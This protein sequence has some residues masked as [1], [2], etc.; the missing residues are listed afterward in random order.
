MSR[1]STRYVSSNAANAIISEVGPYRISTDAL[2]ALNQFL[3][4]ILGMLLSKAQSLDLSRI[5]AVALQILP[6][7]LGKN[8]IVEAELEVKTLTETEVI[9]YEAYERM[10]QLGSDGNFPLQSSIQQLR[11]R[12]LYYSTLADREGDADFNDTSDKTVISPILAIYV[13]TIIEHLAEYLLTTVAVAAEQEDTEFVR[14]R[15]V[16]SALVDDSHVSDAFSKMELKERLEK[17]LVASGFRFKQR[18]NTPIT[19]TP[20]AKALDTHFDQYEMDDDED[21]LEVNN[22]TLHV[23]D[24]GGKSPLTNNFGGRGNTGSTYRPTSVLSSTPSS[25]T[26]NSQHGSVNSKKAFK[27]FNKNGKRHSV[28]FHSFETRGTTVYDP[29]APGLNFEELI[30]SGSTMKMSLTPNRLRTIEIEDQTTQQADRGD[31]W[32]RKLPSIRPESPRPRPREADI[33]PSQKSLPNNHANKKPPPLPR[34]SSFSLL[35]LP[36]S[37]PTSQ[38]Q[39]SH[40]PEPNQKPPIST[41]FDIPLD[42]L[43]SPTTA[44]SP[45][46]PKKIPTE[47]TRTQPTPLGQT[48][49][50]P[51]E[52]N[53]SKPTNRS[54]PD[55]NAKVH[56]SGLNNSTPSSAEQT[57][58]PETLKLNSKEAIG[59]NRVDDPAKQLPVKPA[60]PTSP[61][62]DSVQIARQEMVRSILQDSKQTAKN[63]VVNAV[64]AK[65]VVNDEEA[66]DKDAPI[67]PPRQKPISTKAVTPTRSEQASEATSNTTARKPSLVREANG[68]AGK[69]DTKDVSKSRTNGHSATSPQPTLKKTSNAAMRSTVSLTNIPPSKF[70]AAKAAKSNAAK[71]VLPKSVSEVSLAVTNQPEMTEEPDEM[72]SP[73]PSKAQTIPEPA[74]Q[75]VPRPSEAVERGERKIMS[76]PS[77]PDRP[78]SIVIS[79]PRPSSFVS[80]RRS[81]SGTLPLTEQQKLAGSVEMSVKVWD[82]YLQHNSKHTIIRRRSQMRAGTT[83]ADI[84]SGN[85]EATEVNQSPPKEPTELREQTE[86]KEPRERKQSREYSPKVP[87]IPQGVLEKVRKFERQKSDLTLLD[88]SEAV[89]QARERI[90]ASRKAVRMSLYRTIAVDAGTQTDFPAVDQAVQTGD[91]TS[92]TG[93]SEIADSEVSE[94]GVIDGDEEWFLDDEWEEDEV[95]D[96][97]AVAEWLL[98]C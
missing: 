21:Y 7:S 74:K 41:M 91:L 50:H 13:T 52:P 83:I 84:D 32:A 34:S 37:S 44:L 31:E 68:T 24:K 70:E 18:P 23:S 8:A 47:R 46:S 66:T 62:K 5:K 64:S 80:K 76:R 94:H 22:N 88:S 82:D 28:D 20:P 9:D 63:E 54:L 87:V 12:C 45:P 33:K 77:T 86:T 78:A 71:P 17:R 75:S 58:K 90:A 42:F 35:D 73:V 97:S 11:E 2:Q 30:R 14:V 43:S 55:L 85:D 92:H 38:T 53:L 40:T 96:E 25:L 26:V 59:Q 15:E 56:R 49:K 65:D 1:A 89:K 51:S 93:G 60:T 69:Q 16:F 48:S 19:F 98:G 6:S 61:Q 29:E 27:L 39:R 79:P 72:N 67:R 4:E 57:K 10:R 36:V 3:D 95:E 81:M